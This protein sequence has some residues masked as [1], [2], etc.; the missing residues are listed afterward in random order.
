MSN[1]LGRSQLAIPH[2]VFL[3][4]FGACTSPKWSFQISSEEHHLFGAP[5]STYLSG[6][7]L[8]GLQSIPFPFARV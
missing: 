7:N 8:T 1:D 3:G 6:L 2:G 5:Q 4:E